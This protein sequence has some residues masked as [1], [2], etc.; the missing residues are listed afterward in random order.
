V[1]APLRLL[2]IDT[3]LLTSPWRLDPVE[4]E[5]L[6]FPHIYGPLN[7]DAVVSAEPFRASAGS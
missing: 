3:D 1:T 6:P 2:T 4:G 5:A 7:I